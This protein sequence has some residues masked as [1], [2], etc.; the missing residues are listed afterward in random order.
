M[1]PPRTPRRRGDFRPH[2]QIRQSQVVTTFGPGA[3]VDLPDHSVIIGGLDNW[4]GYRDRQ[5]FED[6]LA[7]KVAKLLHMPSVDFFAPPADKDDPNAQITGITA[8]QFPEWFIAQ[9][10][11]HPPGATVRPRPLVHR[12]DL[13]KG[14]YE[15]DRKKYKVVPI[16]FVQACPRGHVSDINWK[17]FVHGK[18][19]TC[20]RSLW[21]EERGTG[22]E[23]TDIVVRCDCGLSKELSATTKREDVPLGF[24]N[25]PRPWLGNYASEPCGGP[26]G[27]P[28]PNRLLIRSASNSYFAQTLSAIS[29]PEANNAVKAAVELVYQDFLSVAESED[30][31]RKERKKAKVSSALEGL[32]DAD[33]WREV[34][35]RQLGV[36]PPV[37]GIRAAEIET[38]MSAD[39]IG[40]DK[41]GSLFYARAV[42][43]LSTEG[44]MR[45]VSRVVKV[46]RLREVVAQIGFTRFEAS[47]PDVNGE[48]ELGVERAALSLNETWLPAVEN[49]GEGV[50]IGIKRESVDE[51][52]KRD[53]VKHR[54][55]QL[56]RGFQAWKASQPSGSQATF[57]GVEY[58]MLHTLAHLLITA[59]S[60]DCGYAAS[61]IRERIYAVP[62]GLGI[63]LY[64]SSPDA[65]GTLG[66][67]VETADRM[68]L[69][70]DRALA[71]GEL[72]SND[73]VCA[74]HQPDRQEEERHLLGAACHGCVLLP[75]SSCERRNDYLDRALVIPT[76][77][78][79]GAAF[80]EGD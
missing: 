48:L 64:T 17:V 1:S 42:K 19:A 39:E 73:P 59:V 24:C 32:S 14:Q 8:W 20:T 63:L 66:G 79:D 51:W 57:V 36:A 50:F 38:L 69:Y 25:G 47:V 68:P 7:A 29:I 54:A 6:R 76:V 60:L 18:G 11:F 45:H 40:E 67:L 4:S 26:G 22:G 75:E 62:A 80:F 30:D 12:G 77:D 9:G 78:G 41:S 74:Q 13:V 65:E 23:L 37:Q 58:V 61:S 35:R 56:S 3:M 21:L 10:D 15:L 43:P 33:V 71:S 72:C 31:I 34:Q 2:G 46:H 70:L 16:R 27:K 5:I 53:A 52:L 55:E 44:P 28:Q 49:R